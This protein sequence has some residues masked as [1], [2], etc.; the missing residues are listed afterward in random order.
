SRYPESFIL[1]NSFVKYLFRSIPAFILLCTIS[2]SNINCTQS[3]IL[4]Q[5]LVPGVD[6]IHTFLTDTFTVITNNILGTDSSVTGGIN[7]GF[8]NVLGTINS[9]PIFGNTNASIFLQ[10]GLPNN[11]FSFQGSNLVLDSVVLYLNYNGVFGDSTTPEKFNVYRIE[12]PN[13]LLDSPYYSFS[14]IN[15]DQ[16][17]ILGTVTVSPQDLNQNTV[18]NYKDTVS[19]LLKI[20]LSNALGNE[21]LQNTANGAFST[22]STFHK[23]LN[24]LAIIPDSN[25]GGRSL[26][27]AGLDSV[28]TKL[29]VYYKN[30]TRDSLTS[31][32]NF[33]SFTSAHANLVTRN[34]TGAE[35]SKYLNTQNLNGDSLIYLNGRPGIYT[36]IKIPFLQ[37]FPGALINQ[38]ELVITQIPSGPGSGDDVFSAPN[39]LFLFQFD[40]TGH[41]GD[42]VDVIRDP[43]TNIVQNPSYFGGNK[44][45]VINKEGI[46]VAQYHFNISRYVQR[47]L[48]GKDPK[49]NYGFQLIVSDPN[50]AFGRVKVGGGNKSEYRL[51]LNIIYTKL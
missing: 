40:S 13:F 7:S 14:S 51:K 1:K 25:F 34:Y 38:A 27:Y 6:N 12:Q 39:N 29:T 32:F 41:L 44:T 24:G 23:L 5:N 45:M 10:M 21:L 31:D 26:I 11:Q 33:K 35:V 22:D 30:S 4:G 28:D 47:L 20:R 19:H 15:Y 48:T 50:E 8:E 49:G 3:T 16:G 9:D 46:P 37:K 18:I 43:T 17:N 36:K 2:I 42:F